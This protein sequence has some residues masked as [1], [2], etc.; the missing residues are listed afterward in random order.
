MIVE[1]VQSTTTK[2]KVHTCDGEG[3]IGLD[4]SEDIEGSTVVLP[5][6]SCELELVVV[7]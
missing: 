6:E 5:L 1:A 4:K 2:E 3:N 7:R